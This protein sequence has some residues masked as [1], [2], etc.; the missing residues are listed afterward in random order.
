MKTKL[1]ALIASS[2]ALGLGASPAWGQ[3]AP[4]QA[5]IVGQQ[6]A[7]AQNANANANAGQNAVN[8]NVPVTIAGGNV[9]GGSSSANQAATNA[10][11][12]A[13][14]NAASTN[15][16]ALANQVGG[17]SSCA[18]GCGG[19]GQFQAVGQKAATIQNANAKADA[20]QNAVN[21]NVP[22]TIAGGNVSGGT[23]SANQA[24]TNIGAAAAV[25]LASTNQA[26]AANQVGGSSSCIAGCGGAGQFQAVGQ[27]AATI[28]NA[29]ANSNANQNAVNAN[30][31]VTIAGG[32]VVGG[33]SSANQKATNVAGALA[34]NAS[35]TDQLA[36]AN[37]V[38]GSSSCGFG[39]GGAGQFQL[40]SQQAATFQNANANANANQNAVNGNSP[41]TIAGGNV[42][43]GT[44]S[45][46][47]AATNIG[48]AAAV[49]LAS[50]NQA[51][52]A[53]QVGGSSSCIAGCGGAGQ[54]QLIG[55][56]AA[57]FQNAYANA[58]ANQNAVNGNSPVTI[59]GGNVVGG[60][61]SANQAAFNIGA[62]AA[63]NAAYTSQGALANQVGGSSSCAFG[64]GG[65]GQFQA[66]LQQATT[67][68][69]ANANANAYQNAVNSNAPVTIAGGSVV[70]GNSSANQAAFNLGA[71][72]S[73]N[74][75]GTLQQALA[76][77]V[78]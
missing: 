20:K 8:A 65:A 51:A 22:V 47:Q 73:F 42:A 29:N 77:Q 19:A 7:T 74:L 34:L 36:L 57:T 59:A 48:A 26:A 24:A 27:H 15:Q 58:N 2:V 1:M 50:T 67:W 44:S 55:Q 32:N 33:S 37:Q 78:L 69:N 62:A 49:N 66:V 12:A 11:A 17:S 43:G 39:C 4:G 46:N 13:A 52:L 70:G 75:A 3:G 41:V 54:F 25:N 31:P 5:Q 16:A 72:L 14:V 76:N 28:Q 45:A 21:A 60:S 30:V 18:A 9:V 40:V 64:C 35:E 68:Q 53:N 38:G 56:Q 61:S 71:A 6:A 23:S 63:G 10:A